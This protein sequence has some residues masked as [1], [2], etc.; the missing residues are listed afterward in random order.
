[1]TCITLHIINLHPYSCIYRAYNWKW[2]GSCINHRIIFHN[3]YRAIIEKQKDKKIITEH[4]IMMIMLLWSRTQFEI[5]IFLHDKI[6]NSVIVSCVV[7]LKNVFAR[8]TIKTQNWVNKEGWSKNPMVCLT[9]DN[10][11]QLLMT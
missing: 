5:S 11:N 6:T 8:L 3:T 2:I 9:I 7:S 1:M 10:L 4:L